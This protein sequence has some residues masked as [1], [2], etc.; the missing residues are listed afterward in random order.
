MSVS[1]LFLTSFSKSSVNKIL[2][3]RK[4]IDKSQKQDENK[5]L[6]DYIQHYYFAK[7]KFPNKS[8]RN[9]ECLLRLVRL[10]LGFEKM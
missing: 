4:S 7:N 6:A 1:F 10:S 8:T 5:H 2:E 3:I 9:Y